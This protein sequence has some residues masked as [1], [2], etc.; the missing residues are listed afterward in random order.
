MKSARPA[1]THP[2]SGDVVN[3]AAEW[4]VRLSDDDL[5]LADL[6]A[7]QAEFEQWQQT[8]PHH[9]EA[10][11]KML[12]VIEQSKWIRTT[13]HPAS[14]H[15]AMEASLTKKRRNTR[16]RKLGAMLVVIVTLTLPAWIFFQHYPPAYLL[17]D[18]RTG[19]GQWHT[20]TLADN[21]TITLNSA[22]AVNF[23][24]DATQRNLE[25]VH[26]EMLIDVTT[27]PARPFQ[28]KTRHGWIRALGTRFIVNLD[29]ETTTL[30]MLESKAAVML[31]APDR[32]RQTDN[33]A[34]TLTL[35]AG[36]RVQF[37]NRRF[38]GIETVNIREIA[39][40]WKFRHL[41]VENRPLT[42]VLDE[43]SRYR[44]GLIHYNTQALEHMKVSAVLPLDDID[45]ALYLLTRS[46]PIQVRKMTPWLI[47]V[48]SDA[49]TH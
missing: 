32:Q 39:D 27:D 35:D 9:A 15:A 13:A 11:R 10:A 21:S 33:T 16:V 18:V 20:Q 25:L 14:A 3:Q 1:H 4:I 22:S 41:V 19:T 36:Q 28:V 6:A 38:S 30:T 45:T 34:E 8:S 29:N 44:T 17:A 5:T 48:E 43:L 12:A 26:G 2:P 42:E 31:H 37:S 23:D 46:F 7:L 49:T 24:F 47:M 40:A